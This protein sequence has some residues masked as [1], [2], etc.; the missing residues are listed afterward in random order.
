[1]SDEFD[2]RDALISMLVSTPQLLKAWRTSSALESSYAWHLLNHSWQLSPEIPRDYIPHNPRLR[3]WGKPGGWTDNEPYTLTIFRGFDEPTR[4]RQAIWHCMGSVEMNER[5]V[6]FI[7]DGGQIHFYEPNISVSDADIPFDKLN[8]YLQALAEHKVPA[9]TLPDPREVYVT[10]D[11]GSIGFEYFSQN[12]PPA[13]IK[14]EW[15]DYTPAEWQPLVAAITKLREF[16][17]SCFK[18]S[19]PRECGINGKVVPDE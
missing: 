9:I 6:Q 12:Q 18:Q 2:R 3:L 4:C 7:N 13:G 11:V 14:Y 17:L 19:P 16:L 5:I 8:H 1:M 10:T 15:S